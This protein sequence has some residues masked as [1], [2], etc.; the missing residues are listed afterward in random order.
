[1]TR[2]Y[3]GDSAI[4]V[5]R[6]VYADLG[7]FRPWPLFEDYEFSTRLRRAGR[8]AYIRDVSVYA[9]QGGS[10]GAR[11]ERSSRGWASSRST[12]SA[13]GLLGSHILPGCTGRLS[14]PFRRRVAQAFCERRDREGAALRPKNIAELA[15]ASGAI[16]NRCSRQFRWVPRAPEPPA[17]PGSATF[18]MRS[19]PGPEHSR[20]RRAAPE[21]S[22][23]EGMAFP[24]E[25][26]VTRRR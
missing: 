16:T 1:M 15:V 19:V 20:R 12:P 11:S 26:L 25:T 5:R 23:G 8:S 18:R 13:A 17:S 21:R 4:F 10:R 9:A 14:V 22:V 7:G 2:R 24:L 3:Y 6:S